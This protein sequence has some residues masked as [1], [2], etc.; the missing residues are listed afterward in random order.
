[1]LYNLLVM[2]SLD[3]TFFALS[4]FSPEGLVTVT[5]GA[6]GRFWVMVGGHSGFEGFSAIYYQRVA[7]RF[8]PLAP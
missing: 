3:S 5:T 1:M 7:F 2:Q 4:E 8:A 6:D